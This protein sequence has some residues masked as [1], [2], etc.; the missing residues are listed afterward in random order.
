MKTTCRCVIC[1][2]SNT[3]GEYHLAFARG[4]LDRTFARIRWGE[5][6]KTAPEGTENPAPYL[7]QA[8]VMETELSAEELKTLFK[9]IEKKCGR[10]PEGKQEGIIPLDIDLLTFGAQTM[11]P[12]DMGKSYVRQALSSMTEK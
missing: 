10:T 8:A 2:G 9:E 5:I 12:A 1:L 11:K 7:N 4:I 6:V 3:D